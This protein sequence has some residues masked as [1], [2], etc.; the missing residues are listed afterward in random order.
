MLATAAQGLSSLAE[1][2][3][4][5]LECLLSMGSWLQD[6][7]DFPSSW[8]PSAAAYPPVKLSCGWRWAWSTAGLS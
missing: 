4:L 3:L 8:C 5:V 7:T 2:G 1:Q 6:R